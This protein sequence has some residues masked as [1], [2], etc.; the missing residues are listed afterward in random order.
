VK[1]LQE[2]ICM[3]KVVDGDKLCHPN[4]KPFFDS[5]AG[6]KEELDAEKAVADATQPNAPTNPGSGRS[7]RFQ[8]KYVRRGLQ[9]PTISEGD[10]PPARS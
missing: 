10:T 3:L 1:E 7:A 8:E 6:L 9:I 4:V 5:L 2:D